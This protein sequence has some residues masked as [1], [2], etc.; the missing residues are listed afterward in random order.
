MLYNYLSKKQK[1]SQKPVIKQSPPSKHAADSPMENS[2]TP[3]LETKS[4]NWNL[5]DSE[6][7]DQ[8]YVFSSNY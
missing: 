7:D 3:N 5:F 4:S 1:Q 6:V 2:N 8:D